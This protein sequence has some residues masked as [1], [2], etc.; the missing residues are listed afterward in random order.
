MKIEIKDF[1]SV[2]N[3]NFEIKKGI[4][5]IAGKNGSG[6]SQILIA[7]ASNLMK[8]S[9]LLKNLGYDVKKKRYVNNV[10]V[11]ISD[12]TVEYRPAIRDIARD[13]RNDMYGFQKPLTVF[14]YNQYDY[15]SEQKMNQ[16]YKDLFSLITSV[17]LAGTVQEASPDNKKNWGI[18]KEKFEK[19]FGKPLESRTDIP[20]T[21]IGIRAGEEISKFATLS[22]GELEFLSLLVDV[23]I[24]KSTKSNNL[25]LLIDEIDSH[26]HPELQKVII[27]NIEDLCADM[28]VLITTHSP[29]VMLSVTPDRLFYLEKYQ[30]CVD[31]QTSEYTNQITKLSDDSSI[32]EKI[33]ELYSGFSTDSRFAN[34]LGNLAN[35]DLLKYAEDC[36]KDP[37]VLGGG[38]GKQNG[39]QES[40]IANIVM[41]FENPIVVEVGCGMGRTLAAFESIDKDTLKSISYV[42]IEIDEK[43][44]IEIEKFAEENGIREKFKDFKALK[45]YD[46]KS[47]LCIFANVIHE[48]PREILVSELK[49]YLGYLNVQ[50]KALILECLELPVGEK[51]YVVFDLEALKCLLKY[52]IDNGSILISQVSAPTFKGT[53]LMNALI[54][55]KKPETF[56]ILDSDLLNALHKIVEN[57]CIKLQKHLTGEKELT[58]N[59]FAHA[60]HNL[61]HAQMSIL[62]LTKKIDNN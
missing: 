44:I 32:F 35:K 62:S 42:G 20:G 19:V 51:D 9:K 34:Y 14:G 43:N 7:L 25:L 4:N 59:S 50:G 37:E 30:N 15:Y 1:L 24:L 41:T 38:K 23:V 29:S 16:K 53:P 8:S 21:Q 56:D 55:M 13:N 45:E 54:T 31:G 57:E 61:A 27:E 3:V 12:I 39:Q 28:Y 17:K 49:K 26:F 5:V 36:M 33:S 10:K 46:G 60:T 22:T 48:I 47:E 11:S 18:I 52:S 40:A 2:K 58:S 6:K